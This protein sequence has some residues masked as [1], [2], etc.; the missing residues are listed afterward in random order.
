MEKKTLKHK[1]ITSILWSSV[2]RFGTMVISFSTNVVLARLLSPNDFGL[3]GIVLVLIALSDVFIDGGFGSALIQKKDVT[4]E[5]FSTIFFWNLFVSLL[6]YSLLFIFS[7][8][9]EEFYQMPSLALVLRVQGVILILNAFSLIQ[10]IQLRKLMKFR[11]LAKVKITSHSVAAVVGIVMA[12]QGYG[13]W[14]LVGKQLSLSV[15]T[16]LILWIY[17]DW[18]PVFCFSSKSFKSLFKYGSFIFMTS[19]II[20]LY[21]NLVSLIIGK[22]FSVDSLGYYVQA[23]KMEQTMVGSL[24]SV[25]NQVT[26]PVFSQL[27]NDVPRL[28]R[29]VRSSLIALTYLN[30]PLMIFLIII[31]DH[32]IVFLFS[33]TWSASIPYFQILCVAGMVYTLNTVNNNIIKSLGR[34]DL[35]FWLLLTKRIIG[36]VLIIVGLQFEIIGMLIAITINSYISF[37]IGM[38]VSS[39]ISGYTLSTQISDILP[40]YVLSIIVGVTVFTIGHYLYLSSLLYMIVLGLL[41]L[42]LYLLF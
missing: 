22:S 35:Y 33:E 42:A 21:D 3:F 20:K 19:I 8:F 10:Q 18:K 36:I 23:K 26:F 34:S 17:S 12:V 37:I 31:A 13:V 15:I 14:S 11:A 4:V 5:D 2:H 29:G 6:L 9:I 24:S 1:T 30:F 40:S 7:P 25:V 28:V 39:R 41:Y 27:Q 38:I 16:L 32:L